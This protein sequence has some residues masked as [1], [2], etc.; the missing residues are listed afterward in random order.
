M[1]CDEQL[2][3]WLKGN[4]IH[5]DDRDECCPDFSCCNPDSLV[6]YRTRKA[7]IDG[8]EKTRI[9]M[10]GMFLGNAF[11]DANIHLVGFDDPGRKDM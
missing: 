5:N 8:D 4:S 11:S 2:A 3:E 7:F 9:S 6:D 1:T 10:L